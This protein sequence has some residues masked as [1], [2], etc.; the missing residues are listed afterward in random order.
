MTTTIG[1]YFS[2]T[3]NQWIGEELRVTLPDGTTDYMK[4][5]EVRPGDIFVGHSVLTKGGIL[6]TTGYE[7]QAEDGTLVV[8]AVWVYRPGMKLTITVE[9]QPREIDA[10]EVVLTISL[11]DPQAEYLLMATLGCVVVATVS[12]GAGYPPLTIAVGPSGNALDSWGIFHNGAEVGQSTRDFDHAVSMAA[13]TARL[14]AK[15]WAGGHG[16]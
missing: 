15:R 3:S 16:R 1:T 2:R 8:G 12:D 11:P 13:A 14:T 10:P 7:T 4:V 9:G 5:T 6:A